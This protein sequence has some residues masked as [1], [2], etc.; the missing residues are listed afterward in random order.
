MVA[1]SELGLQKLM[2]WLNTIAG[3]FCMKIN[4]MKRNIM[5]VSN[6]PGRKQGSM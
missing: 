6:E 1:G 5:V 2:D 3:K 4:G